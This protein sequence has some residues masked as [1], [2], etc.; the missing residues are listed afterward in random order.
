[1]SAATVQPSLD[2]ESISRTYLAAW[3]ARDPSRIAALHADDTRFQIH[4]GGELVEGRDAVIV[5]F[6]QFLRSWPNF[7]FETERLLFGEDHWVLD[8]TM[9]SSGGPAGDVRLDC[10]DI[11]TVDADGLVLRKDSY[12]DATG[13]RA[14]DHA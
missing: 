14:G 11:V 2:L 8:W 9:L 1:M 3:T 6:E 13:L 7:A 12:L 5:A 10:V 4:V